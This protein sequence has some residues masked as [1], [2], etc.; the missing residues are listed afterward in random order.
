VSHGCVVVHEPL[1]QTLSLNS[2]AGQG[3]LGWAS[4]VSEASLIPRIP[5]QRISSL[6]VEGYFFGIVIL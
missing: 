3:T 2:I 5:P 1:A 4:P 6:M